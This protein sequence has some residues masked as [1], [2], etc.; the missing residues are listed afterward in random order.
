[1]N[2]TPRTIIQE[3]ADYYKMPLDDIYCIRQRKDNIKSKHIAIYFL[4]KYTKM[5]LAAIGGEFPGRTGRLDHASI[6]HALKSV[7]N[8]I[9]TDKIYR[10]EIE[11]IESKIRLYANDKVQVVESD[12]MENDFYTHAELQ[13]TNNSHYENNLFMG[14]RKWMDWF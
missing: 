1:M 12:F 2:L 9:D 13:L 3:V 7:Q 11:E 5:L 10:K 14:N 4:K 8:Q 6:S